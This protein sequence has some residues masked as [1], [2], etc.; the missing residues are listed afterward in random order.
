M[1][2]S[3]SCLTTNGCLH[4]LTFFNTCTWWLKVEILWFLLLPESPL[5]YLFL[6]KWLKTASC[7][8]ST[9]G[10]E[11]FRSIPMQAA[12]I[13][14]VCGPKPRIV[15]YDG[16][17]RKD[18]LPTCSL[19]EAI[20]IQG[21]NHAERTLIKYPTGRVLLLKY[22]G[23]TCDRKRIAWPQLLSPSE[24]KQLLLKKMA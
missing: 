15:I 8:L 23:Y 17:F 9:K 14:P 12:Y 19:E 11:F 1:M 21:S 3:K 7:P 22:S 2:A 4:T 20:F 5:S 6:P 24:F 18:L 16:G 10:M 13:C